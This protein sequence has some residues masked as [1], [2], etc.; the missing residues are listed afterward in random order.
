ME[1][2]GVPVAIISRWLGH[3]SGA[4]TMATYVRA[5]ASDLDQGGDALAAIYKISES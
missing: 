3:H 4:F 5:E 1:K 2:A